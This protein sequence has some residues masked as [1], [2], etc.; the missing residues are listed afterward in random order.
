[1]TSVEDVGIMSV[2]DHPNPSL[3]TTMAAVFAEETMK[4][5]TVL[6]PVG[7]VPLSV[8]LLNVV[9]LAFFLNYYRILDLS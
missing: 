5:K 6:E 1:M 3:P 7:V 4:T 8:L 2:V 9:I